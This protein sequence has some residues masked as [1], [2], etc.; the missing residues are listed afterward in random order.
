VSHAAAQIPL[1]HTCGLGQAV[2][3]LPHDEV[4]VLV[5]TQ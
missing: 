5:F 3:Q 1:E 2:P 4:D